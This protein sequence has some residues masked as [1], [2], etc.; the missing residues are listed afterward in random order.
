MPVLVKLPDERGQ[1]LK[2]IAEREGKTMVEVIEDHIHRKIEEGVI[3]ADLPGFE[4]EIKQGASISLKAMMAEF[5]VVVSDERA[6]LA[7]EVLRLSANAKSA[8]EAMLR[9]DMI[10][11]VAE[12]SLKIEGTANGVRLIDLKSG[13]TYTTT[14]SVAIDI[15]EQIERVLNPSAEK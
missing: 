11:K 6:K 1:Q 5:E 3:P 12:G 15:A 9:R 14:S 4:V 8:T 10:K 2:M 13:K 7:A